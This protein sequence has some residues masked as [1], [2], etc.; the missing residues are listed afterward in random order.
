MQLGDLM[1]RASDTSR[2]RYFLYSSADESVP[3]VKQTITI[4]P[5][6]KIVLITFSSADKFSSHDTSRPA[7][8]FH[9]VLLSPLSQS[10]ISRAV[11]IPVFAR[12]CADGSQS[13]T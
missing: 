9:K 6:L 10:A 3:I 5:Y 13:G 1:A 8:L 2:Y 11:T 4:P 7:H 12:R